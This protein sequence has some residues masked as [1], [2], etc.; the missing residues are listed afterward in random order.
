MYPRL[1][2]P[3]SETEEHELFC[4]W[5]TTNHCKLT[6][7]SRT[8]TG[9]AVVGIILPNPEWAKAFEM[10][11]VNNTWLQQSYW[12]VFSGEQ[13]RPSYWTILHIKACIFRLVSKESSQ[14][15]AKETKCIGPVHDVCL[16]TLYKCRTRLTMLTWGSRAI[17]TDK[18]TAKKR[19]TC[20][21]TPLNL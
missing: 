6:L 10:S 18:M 9:N 17:R 20:A 15:S 12:S 19:L 3:S 14:L 7:K 21:L 11:A 5:F 16:S 8:Q 4:P 1:Y 2:S 13:R